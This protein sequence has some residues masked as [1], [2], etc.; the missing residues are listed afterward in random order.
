MSDFRSHKLNLIELRASGG[1]FY[2][3][4]PMPADPKIFHMCNPI[5]LWHH[6]PGNLPLPFVETLRRQSIWE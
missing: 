2:T 5:G 1:S 6:L 4:V 3:H